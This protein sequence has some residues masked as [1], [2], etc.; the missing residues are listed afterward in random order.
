[1][2]NVYQEFFEVLKS[3]LLELGVEEKHDG[4]EG[5]SEAEIQSLENKVGKLPLAYRAYLKSIGKKFLFEFMDAEDMAFD[6]HDY[7][8][9]FAAE[10]F[11][12]N[13]LVIERPHLVISERR[14]EYISLI[15]LDEGDNPKTW[16]M[17]E[18]WD[19]EDKG[20][21]LRVRTNSFTDLMLGFFSSTLHYFPATFLFVTQEE[22]K[23]VEKRF[24]RY[25]KSQKKIAQQ[26]RKSQTNNTIVKKLN[27]IFMS[28]YNAEN[29][30]EDD[31]KEQLS[32]ENQVNTK[33]PST[34]SATKINIDSDKKYAIVYILIIIAIGILI[35][36]FLAYLPG[37]IYG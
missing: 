4:I 24:E 6:D 8:E 1:M 13:N 11:E 33:K 21:N 18:Y 23:N 22:K 25:N 3:Y 7:I 28:Y 26:I 31:K 36:L 29:G 17:S 2:K 16:I 34:T 15:Y 27:E 5:C 19:E 14:S 10:V 32:T 9:E 35:G 20:D 37:L 30:I 12:E